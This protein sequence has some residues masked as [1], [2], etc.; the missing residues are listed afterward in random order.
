MSSN[1]LN[2]TIGELQKLLE[3]GKVSSVELNQQ[4]VDHIEKHNSEVNAFIFVDKDFIL[5]QAKASD[6][7][8]S[9]SSLLSSLDGIPIAIKNNIAIEDQRLTCGSHILENFVSPYD[10]TVTTRLKQQ[11]MVLYSGLNMDEFA[12]GST[13]ESSYFGATSN[14]WNTERSPGGSSGGSSAS[15]AA[16]FVP[17]SLGS[18]TGGSIRQPGAFCGVYGLKPTY[19]QVSRYG[20]VAFASSLDQIGPLSHSVEDCA[21]V[22]DIIAGHDERDSSSYPTLDINYLQEIQNLEDYRPRIGIPKEY[23]AHD[24]DPEAAK[25]IDAVIDF[26]KTKGC[27]VK[28]ITLPNT[29]LALSTYYIIATA[30][31]S[32]NL[33]RFD[34]IRYTH[35]SGEAKNIMDT[36][37][38]SRGEGFGEEVT[39][40]VILGTF[41]LSSG[42]HDAYYSKAQKVRT[43]IRRDFETAFEDIDLVL[44]PTAP[45]PAFKK[46]ENADDPLMVYLNDIFTIP[47]NLAGLP[48]L[49]VPCGF[50]Q[51]GLPLS[52]QLIAPYFKE[53]HLL[54]TAKLFEDAHDYHNQHPQ[55]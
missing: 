41:A 23:F 31:A 27:E 5:E 33:A 22:L 29:D 37:F 39:R 40:R 51:T 8:R 21:K 13:T 15:V 34:G 48:G 46:G 7:R 36:Y 47:V 4:F 17:V 43:L 11:G 14:P 20:L 52:Y 45:T 44:T 55:F 53:E 30:E 2:A 35:R 19:G 9:S 54:K 32:S 28:D 49:S 25:A 42:Y 38:M 1:L 26:Y 24:I 10:A 3:S 50:T 18:D 6:E 12:M 16:R